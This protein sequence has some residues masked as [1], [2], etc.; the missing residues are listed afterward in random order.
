M[1]CE[2][3]QQNIILAQYGELADDA[4]FSLEQH[5]HGCEDCRREWNAT[6]ALGEELALLPMLEPSPNLLA[7]SRMRLDDALDAM[8]PRSATQRL[9]SSAFRWLGFVQG[10]PALATLL[11]GIGFLSGNLLVRYQVRQSIAA[12]TGHGSVVVKMPAAEGAIAS[13]SGIVPTPNSDLVEV[14]YN[15]L[16]PESYQ[17]TLSDPH[18]RELLMLGTKLATNSDVHAGAVEQLA[19]VGKAG[20]SCTDGAGVQDVCRTL[21]ASLRYDKSPA[22]RLKALEGLQQYVA[23]DEAVRNAVLVSLMRDKSED[24]RSQAISVLTPVQADSS[25]RQILRTVSVQDANPAIRLASYQVLQGGAN[26]Q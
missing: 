10:A 2:I 8:P 6:L 1:K 3:A 7:A 19:N 18:V 17:G 4:Q 16:V 26:V 15:R 12:E 5:L 24:V 21:M 20:Q 9:V 25:V 13:V 11:I 23:Q 22:V 14:K